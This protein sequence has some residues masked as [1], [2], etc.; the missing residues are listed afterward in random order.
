MRFWIVPFYSIVITVFMSSCGLS[1]PMTAVFRNSRIILKDYTPDRIR[2]TSEYNYFSIRR[3]AILGS[4]T[5]I[6]LINADN[7]YVIEA[8]HIRRVAGYSSDKPYYYTLKKVMYDKRRRK[9]LV[10]KEKYTCNGIK[11]MDKIIHYENGKKKNTE[12]CMI[13]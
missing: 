8:T 3:F 4:Y 13:N 10:T 12:D 6:N 5:N 7:G 1:R 11:I 2:I 9:Q